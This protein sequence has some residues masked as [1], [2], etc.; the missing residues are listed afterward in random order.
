MFCI[1]SRRP[2][3]QVLVCAAILL[4]SCARHFHVQGVVLEVDRP[5]QTLTVSHRAIPGYM[6]AM[7]MPFHV[8][9]PRDLDQL[10]PGSRIDFQLKVTHAATIVRH[11]HLQGSA[12]DGIPIPKAEGK[13]SI[14]GALP[15]F[16]LTAQDGRSVRLS[17]FQGQLVAI[18]F[19]YTRCPLPDVCPRLSAN[20]ARLQKHFAGRMVLLSI[21]LDPRYDTPA[22]LAEYAAQQVEA[23]A[24]VIQIFDSWAGAL[25]PA[26][27]RDFV[28]PVTKELI[29]KVQAL[30]VPV[31]YFGVDTATLL[32][33]MRETGADVI[34]LDWRV[35][36][37][38]GWSTLG[39]AVAVQG[40]LDPI[41][42]FAEP[43][44]LRQRVRQILEQAGGRPGH[45]FN[46]GHGIVPS[47]PVENVQRVVQY[48]R[49]FNALYV[50]EFSPGDDVRG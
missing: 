48:V 20:F 29:R 24:D 42:L 49:E 11:V 23:G 22:V 3:V 6:E 47:T 26:D 7:T 12:L 21:T 30:G 16:T 14:G 46:V 43:D 17:S 37:D 5:H 35:P 15:D 38:Q 8:E 25:S 31:I 28:L 2:R 19:I 39:H 44:L 9:S 10:Q 13:I 32:P 45:I 40:N 27:Y 1:S 18:D 33:A 34:G 4:S 41:L 50:R 36:L